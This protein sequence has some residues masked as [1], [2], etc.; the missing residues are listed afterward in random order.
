ML[1]E[2]NWKRVTLEAW[3]ELLAHQRQYR[4]QIAER[5]EAERERFY[6]EHKDTMDS[7]TQEELNWRP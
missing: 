4:N 1:A 2:L 6:R 5:Q 3:R 7:L